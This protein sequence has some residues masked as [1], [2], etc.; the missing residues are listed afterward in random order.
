MSESLMLML[1]FG[2]EPLLYIMDSERISSRSSQN[3]AMWGN[4]QVQYKKVAGLKNPN[5]DSYDAEH[6]N[7]D[8][9]LTLTLK[10]VGTCQSLK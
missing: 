7:D 4:P 1:N 6:R 10:M 8:E 9:D 2:L 3:I 5:D